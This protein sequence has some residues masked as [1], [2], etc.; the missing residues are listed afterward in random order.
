MLFEFNGVV[1]EIVLTNNIIIHGVVLH[2]SYN[3]LG[4]GDGVEETLQES[5]IIYNRLLHEDGVPSAR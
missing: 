4:E 2:F 3:N 1:I 5:L